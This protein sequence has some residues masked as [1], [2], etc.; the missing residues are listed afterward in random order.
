[1]DVPARR[2]L[3]D[4]HRI[5]G[6]GCDHRLSVRAERQAADG[7]IMGR[8]ATHRLAGGRVP[9]LYRLVRV[10]GNEVPA[11]GA[12]RHTVGEVAESA[13]AVE[14]LARA[15]FPDSH[16]AFPASGETLPIWAEGD[17]PA[18]LGVRESEKVF[19]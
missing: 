4:L 6:A 1:M 8:D 18:A 13:Q 3:P 19:A 5:I 14:F 11:V 12:E 10:G 2:Q 7:I 15:D 17:A 16:F 9:H